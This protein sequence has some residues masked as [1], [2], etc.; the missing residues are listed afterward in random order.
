MIK[1]GKIMVNHATIDGLSC[2][3]LITVNFNLRENDIDYF[4]QLSEVESGR[5]K[6]PFFEKA[7]RLEVSY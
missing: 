2:I 4:Y 1:D 5:T 7:C 3:R 6:K